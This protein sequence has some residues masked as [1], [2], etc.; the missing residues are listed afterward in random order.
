MLKKFVMGLKT[1]KRKINNVG[2]KE[3]RKQLIKIL[4]QLSLPQ[5]KRQLRK[6][7]EPYVKTKGRKAYDRRMI[8]T[9]SIYMKSNNIHGYREMERECRNN[10][11]LLRFT[12]KQTPGHDVF[13]R[14]FRETDRTI[15][16]KI[17]YGCLVRFNDYNYLTFEKLFIDST[18]ALVNASINYT[19]NKKQINALKQIQ[20]WGLLH[21]GKRYNIDSMVCELKNMKLKYQNDKKILKL[22]DIALKKPK[23]YTLKNYNKIPLFEKAMEENNTSTVPISFPEARILKS[24]RKRY[25][26]GLM[27]QSLMLKNHI[28]FGIYLLKDAND[29]KAIVNVINELKEDLKIFIDLIKE[30]GENKANIE[31][32]KNLCE[33]MKLVCDSGYQTIE[34]ILYALNE[35]ISLIMMSRAVARQSNNKQREELLKILGN[36][37]Q[38]KEKE[39][40]SMK[41]CIRLENAFECPFKR[42][43][44]LMKIRYVNNEYNR[45][46]KGNPLLTQFEFN[47]YCE[48]CSGCPFFEKYGEPCKCAHIKIITTAFE[49]NL[50]N[51]CI[52]DEFKEDY[53]DR[54][55][56]SERINAYFK[57]YGLLHLSGRNFDSVKNESIVLG[58]AHNII[59]FDNLLEV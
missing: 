36:P 9:L 22:I 54:F 28:L 45:N 11:V 14:F 48:D 2:D 32:L 57:K 38:E 21:D 43:I 33:K 24:K 29:S 40:M 37:K 44:K 5:I 34:N 13:R 25:D 17:F 15:L 41:D 8:L 52:Q 42:L 30:F 46:F 59:R 31:E 4:K 39:N 19:I 1:N 6:L 51:E 20:E 53:Q 10:I 16:K 7:N 47:H 58:I 18:D 12:G 50:A 23:I 26:V 49:Y 55:H 35:N 3:T 56:I 27:L